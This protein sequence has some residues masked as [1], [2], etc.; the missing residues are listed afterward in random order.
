MVGNL[1]TATDALVKP[2]ETSGSKSKSGSADNINNL[3][4][5]QRLSNSLLN[6]SRVSHEEAL[7][8][9]LPLMNSLS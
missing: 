2:K 7:D 1:R 8:I 6:Y 9:L 4:S 3:A 5:K